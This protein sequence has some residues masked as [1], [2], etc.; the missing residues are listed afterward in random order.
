MGAPEISKTPG[1]PSWCKTPHGELSGEEDA[2][3]IGPEFKVRRATLRLCA[4]TDEAT[5][6]TEGPYVLVG[7]HQFDVRQTAELVGVLMDLLVDAH[8]PALR[9]A[10]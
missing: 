7:E 2:V 6:T 5:G 9:E 10:V 1:C 3:H 8:D 4:T